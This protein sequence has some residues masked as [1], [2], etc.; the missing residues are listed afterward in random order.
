MRAHD[1]SCRFLFLRSHIRGSL[2]PS[3][4]V[5]LIRKGCIRK[6]GWT[7]CNEYNEYV[8]AARQTRASGNF[9]IKNDLAGSGKPRI[10]WT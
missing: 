2:V 9:Q 10:L 1:A 5:E 3:S 4:P 6:Q 8:T 7:P